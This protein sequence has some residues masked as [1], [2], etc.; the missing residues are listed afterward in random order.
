M[1]AAQAAAP[2]PLDLSHEGFVARARALDPTL[3]QRAPQTAAARR[4]LDATIQDFQDAGFFRMLQPARYGGFELDPQTFFAVQIAIAEACPSSAWVLGVVA[5]HA[6]QLAL[7]DDKAQQE[8]W[9]D[10]TST[11][12]SSSYAPVGKVTRVDGGF[13]LSGHWSFSSGSDH[14][15]WAFLGAFCPPA[16]GARGPD[17]R[18]F[19]VPRSDYRIDDVWNVSGLQGTGSND[20]IVEDVFVPEHRTHKMGD[21]FKRVSPGNAVNTSPLFK[22]PFGQV[23]VRAVSTTAIG[24]AKGM[25]EAYR[26]VA[27]DKVA[28]SDQS[29]VAED[30]TS[31]VL[32]AQCAA[33]ID[34]IE[35]V[36]YRNFDEM[37]ALA[38]AGEDMS[39]DQRVAWRY[40]SARVVERSREVVDALFTVSGGR[41]LWVD[42]PLNRYFQDMHAA[43]AHYA[44]NPE[45]PGRNFGR[46]ALGMRTQDYFI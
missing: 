11:L 5:V 40:Q 6:W 13:R 43:R 4:L 2:G 27:A 8:V 39:I 42:S 36:L 26:S 44:N 20:V 21:G 3:R 9:G 10:D 34:E 22:L 1:S 15:Q 35:L 14:C 25:L 24:I 16:P 17:M 12:I 32:L 23:F 41:A 18:T 31:Q 33:T 28:T 45:K 29:K 46:V 37:M 38:R 30:P 7:F 19:L